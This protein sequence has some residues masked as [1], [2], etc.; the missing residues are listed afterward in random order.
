SSPSPSTT[1][2]HGLPRY[3]ELVK[4]S[5]CENR[6]SMRRSLAQPALAV[7]HDRR[8]QPQEAL[9]GAERGGR[10]PKTAGGRGGADRRWVI[11]AVDRQLIAAAPAGRQVGLMSRE[12]ERVPAERAGRIAGSDQ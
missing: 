7:D 12:S 8:T 11:G 1:T 4:Q 2:A 10:D 5:T 6:R 3:A 9:E